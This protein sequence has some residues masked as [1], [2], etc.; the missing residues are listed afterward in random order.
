MSRLQTEM[1]PIP[2]AQRQSRAL[3]HSPGWPLVLVTSLSGKLSS[4]IRCKALAGGR[5]KAKR[6]HRF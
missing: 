2:H 4:G 1:R 3:T 5:T 6:V